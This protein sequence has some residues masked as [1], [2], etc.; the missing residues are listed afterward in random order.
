ME[1]TFTH[2]KIN[3]YTDKDE[4]QRCH[5]DDLLGEGK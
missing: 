2:E 3:V 5:F 4:K 1:Q